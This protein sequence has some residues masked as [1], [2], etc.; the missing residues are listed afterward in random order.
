VLLIKLSLGDS[1]P[2]FLEDMCNIDVAIGAK[3]LLDPL[4]SKLHYVMRLFL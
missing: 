2:R 4:G 1:P 3:H